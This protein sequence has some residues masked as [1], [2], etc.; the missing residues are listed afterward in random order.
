MAT[1]RA[2]TGM[3]ARR[4]AGRPRARDLEKAG[5]ALDIEMEEVPG[6]GCS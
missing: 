6:V 1:C 2:K 4:E 3:S 5:H